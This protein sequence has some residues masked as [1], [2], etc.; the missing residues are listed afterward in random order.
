MFVRKFSKKTK[1]I[2]LTLLIVSILLCLIYFYYPSIVYFIETN[3]NITI[4]SKTNIIE[5][6]IKPND[7]VNNKIKNIQINYKDN[8]IYAQKTDINDFMINIPKIG[9][10]SIIISGSEESILDKGIWHLDSSATPDHKGG[11]IVIMGH[12][13]QYMPPDP[14]T[15]YLL[16]KLEKDDEILLNYQYNLYKYK[17]EEKKVVKPEDIGIY[18]Q[19]NKDQVTLITC[20]P[21]YSTENRLVIIASLVKNLNN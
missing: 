2:I 18:R 11:N 16:D 19:N 13:W 3:C 6:Q 9:V 1:I 7:S 20:D 12:R 14:R 10:E 4:F 5:K 17:V 21:I 15:F 8:K